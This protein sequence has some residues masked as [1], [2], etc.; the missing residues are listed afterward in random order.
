[1]VEMDTTGIK[2]YLKKKRSEP[3]H[4]GAYD[5]DHCGAAV[6]RH[7]NFVHN[8]TGLVLGSQSPWAEAGLFNVG[9]RHVITIE[10]MKINSNYPGHS[11]FHPSEVANLYLKKQWHHVDFAFSFSSI[12]HDGLGRYGDPIDP[13]ADFET[14]ARIRCLLKPGGILFLGVP[15]APD[16][17]AYNAHRIYGKYRLALLLLGWDLI[18]MFPEKCDVV[19]EHLH[20]SYTCQP[21]IVLQKPFPKS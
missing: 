3:F 2:K 4:C 16:T 1:M 18:D 7:L 6:E 20:G 10:Y 11:S 13:Y 14:L 17:I 21:V 15:V 5:E 9:A 12:E 19:S 8:R